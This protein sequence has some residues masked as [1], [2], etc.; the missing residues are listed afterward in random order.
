MEVLACF[1]VVNGD[2]KDGITMFSKA[3]VVFESSSLL[4]KMALTVFLLISVRSDLGEAW[5][6]FVSNRVFYKWWSSMILVCKLPS[7]FLIK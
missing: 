4:S 6:Y 1:K 7:P 3:A 2:F 5:T